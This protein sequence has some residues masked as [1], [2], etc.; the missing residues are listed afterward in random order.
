MHNNF[1]KIGRLVPDICSR[2]DRQTDTILRRPYAGG[3]SNNNISVDC[4]ALL[5]TLHA[6]MRDWIDIEQLKFELS[7]R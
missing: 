1:A 6:A 3:G 2:T 4:P 5:D 7:G